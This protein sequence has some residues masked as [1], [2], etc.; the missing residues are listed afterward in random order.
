METE[1]DVAKVIRSV[2]EVVLDER[3]T[4]SDACFDVD[5]EVYEALGDIYNDCKGDCDAFIVRVK[6]SQL[7]VAEEQAFTVFEGFQSMSKSIQK[8]LG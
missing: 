8:K 5:S 2:G 3:S 7:E 4:L 1:F 6:D